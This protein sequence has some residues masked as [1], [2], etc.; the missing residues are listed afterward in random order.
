MAASAAP[1]PQR[2]AVHPLVE[3]V[4]SVGR[5]GETAVEIGVLDDDRAPGPNRR[6]HLPE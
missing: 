6:P 2:L 4:P 1:A 5:V 3:V